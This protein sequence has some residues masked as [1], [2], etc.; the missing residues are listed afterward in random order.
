MCQRIVGD[1]LFFQNLFSEWKYLYS[2]SRYWRRRVG[3][4]RVFPSYGHFFYL[5]WW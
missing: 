3:N 5:T 4:R 2:F 1:S